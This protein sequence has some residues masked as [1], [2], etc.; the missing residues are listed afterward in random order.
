MTDRIRHITILTVFLSPFIFH[1]SPLQAQSYVGPSIGG[2]LALTTD[3]LRQTQVRVGGGGEV[4]FAYEWQREHL[5]IHTGVG[6]SLQCPS[7][8]V[9]SQWLEQEMLDTRGVAVTYRGLLN[10]RT[11][12]LL[13]HQLTVPFMV[14]GTWRGVYVLVGAKLSVALAATARQ[15][16]QLY[17]AGDYQGRY[18]DWFE[19]MPN[20]GYHDF[21]PVQSRHEMAVNRFDLRLAAE[22]G[23]TF[24]LNPYTGLKPSPLLRVGLFA[25]YG[26]LNFLSSESTLPRT[27]ADW[28]QYLHVNMTHIYAS[29]ESAGSRANLLSYGIRLTLL[30]PTSNAPQPSNKCL[31]LGIW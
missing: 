7:L 14:G 5:L 10:Q 29:E 27:T 26:M 16:A 17:T 2:N 25:E 11:D 19:D 15:D 4:G 22:L 24:V 6:Y 30:F 31:C 21:E 20:H 28:R 18:Y 1:F 12:R 3:D 9:D 8:A 13:M 23:Y